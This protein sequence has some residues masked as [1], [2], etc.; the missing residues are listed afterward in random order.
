M[1]TPNEQKG[2]QWQWQRQRHWH[3]W[4]IRL[5]VLMLSLTL[6]LQTLTSMIDQPDDGGV[7]LAGEAEE[8]VVSIVGEDETISPAEEVPALVFTTLGLEAS[9]GRT[10]NTG[11]PAAGFPELPGKI[12]VITDDHESYVQEYSA[13]QELIKKYGSDNVI[14]VFWSG[15]EESEWGHPTFS[16]V[17]KDLSVKV[18]IVN[19]AW[20]GTNN[21]LEL[22][23]RER[24]DLFIICCAPSDGVEG[25]ARQADLVMAMDDLMM[26]PVMVRRAHD[27]GAKTFVHYS[28][29]RHMAQVTLSARRKLI[30]EE[31]EKLGI[32]YF[33][34]TA[35]DP[36]NAEGAARTQLFIWEDA[37]KWV[38]QYGKDTAFF[39][40]NCAMQ[41]TLIK[42]VA[43]IGAIYPQPCCPSPFHGF[44]P[45]L[46]IK[47]GDYTREDAVRA[48][49]QTRMILQEKG[50]AA[51]FSTW[52]VSATALMTNAA[53]AYGVKWMKGE[54]PKD[55]I[56]MEV[57]KACMVEY[58][59]VPVYLRTYSDDRT[60]EN[61][62]NFILLREEYYSYEDAFPE[63]YSLDDGV[64]LTDFP[65]YLEADTLPGNRPGH[66]VNTSIIVVLND[67]PLE[68]SLPLLERNGRTFYPM[69]ELLEAFD[70]EVS[71]DSGRKMASGKL[72][73]NTVEFFID[74]S[75]YTMNGEAQS[76]EGGL[77]SFIEKDRTYIPIR[78]AAEGL[79]FMVQWNEAES[80]IE[81]LDAASIE[82]VLITNKHGLPGKIA[83]ITNAESQNA[84]AYFSAHE[85]IREYG[86]DNVIH[87]TWP[88]NFIEEQEQMI[89]TVNKVAWDPS[90]KVLIIN[91]A[92]PGT[93]NAVDALLKKRDDLFIV[94]CMPQDRQE[95][96]IRQANLVVDLDVEMGYIMMMQAQ[97][98]GAKTFVHYSF[99]RHM[100]QPT[101][102]AR[103]AVI[104][105]TCERDREL[106]FVDVIVPDPA[107]EAGK[108]AAHRFILEDVP[109]MIDQ[110]GKD[111]AFFATECSL[112]PSLIKAV[113]DNGAIYPQPCCPSLYH[114]FPNALGFEPDDYT[115]EGAYETLKQ[116]GKILGDRGNEARISTWLVPATALMTN[117]TAAY[118]V[119]WM[120][121]EV[122][123]DV[124]S[125]E[126][127]GTCMR[128]YAGIELYLSNFNELPEGISDQHYFVIRNGYYVFERTAAQ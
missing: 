55:G 122:P 72:G 54:V 3:W 65:Q 56:D 84:E 68:F 70:A 42:V 125:M 78:F 51:R 61:Y 121:G 112:Q 116:I 8:T 106:E 43:D 109:K 21:G 5:F 117:T 79:G 101:Y 120:K 46:G 113:V 86:S 93:C 108:E 100:E 48:L 110:Y 96:V 13:T 111:T 30:M 29:P 19:L 83:L 52:P 26:G 31:C 64:A 28:F 127:L 71:W 16:E 128:D 50:V 73:D 103:R 76:M 80:I 44:S 89:S 1:K 47:P 9:A 57:L 102:S 17:A 85:V 104:K 81:I 7:L 49:N 32:E 36:T 66:S 114:G 69:R 95:D 22:L 25:I 107:S 10:S 82:E 6:I 126:I 60:M 75:L 91:Q 98:F 58:A 40:T 88:E 12:A 124:I 23:L 119:K 123:K 15:R 39:A 14:S 11:I 94:Y 59:G 20:P 77:T 105:E 41:T 24:D 67:K 63:V 62:E 92:L 34:A 87:L 33:D 4:L 45:A 97:L 2:I 27:L 53:A 18:L 118:G 37:P 115:N 74:T 90:V 99:P 35:P 38:E